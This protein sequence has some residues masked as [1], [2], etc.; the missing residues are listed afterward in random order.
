MHFEYR[1]FNVVVEKYL[2][3]FRWKADGEEPH[4]VTLRDREGGDLMTMKNAKYKI[5]RW[6]DEYLRDP[7]KFQ[8]RYP[9]LLR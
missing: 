4:F 7:K 3:L 2:G 8:R 9:E 6:I 1:G 5:K